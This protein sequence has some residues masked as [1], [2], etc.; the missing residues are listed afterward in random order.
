MIEEIEPSTTESEA[1]ALHPLVRF[2]RALVSGHRFF[3]RESY[4][5]S[6]TAFVRHPFQWCRAYWRFMWLTITH[7]WALMQIHKANT[8]AMPTASKERHQH[9]R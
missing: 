4:S 5:Y 1:V 7:E 2:W 3:I 6:G 9:N 8:P